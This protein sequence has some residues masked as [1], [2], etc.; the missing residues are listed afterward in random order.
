MA[1]DPPL[2]RRSP[3]RTIMGASVRATRG[4]LSVYYSWQLRCDVV[5]S[6]SLI[7]HL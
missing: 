2:D 4:S 7:G 5:R 6:M 3:H 1:I